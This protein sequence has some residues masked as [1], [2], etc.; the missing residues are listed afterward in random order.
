ME[1]LSHRPHP[2]FPF[3]FGKAAGSQT[4]AGVPAST[5]PVHPVEQVKPV[6]EKKQH[7]TC[8]LQVRHPQR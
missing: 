3:Q 7:T 4:G 5:Q 1:N 2:L 6:A 8:K